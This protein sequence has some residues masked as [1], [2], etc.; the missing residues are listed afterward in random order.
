MRLTYLGKTGGSNEGSC[1]AL[2]RTD[3]GT[4]VVQGK[5]I[6]DPEALGDLRDLAPDEIA[7][8]VPWDVLDLPREVQ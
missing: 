8:E 3:R 1:P 5:Q 4:A 7:V 2:Y 6:T